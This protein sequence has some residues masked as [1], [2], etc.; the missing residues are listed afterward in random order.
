M[1]VSLPDWQTAG[2]GE[3]KKKEEEGKEEQKMIQVSF[4]EKS[5]QEKMNKHAKEGGNV[6]GTTKDRRQRSAD[7]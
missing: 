1:V 7:W 4:K 3:G 2:K 6:V 5:E